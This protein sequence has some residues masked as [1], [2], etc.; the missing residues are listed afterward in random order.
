MKVLVVDNDH[1]TADALAMLLK[2]ANCEVRVAY[3]GPSALDQATKFLPDLLLADLAMPRMD[4]NELAR[5]V[6]ETKSLDRTVLAVISGYA[7]QQ[8]R[9]LATAAGFTE[10]LVKPIPIEVIY[11][12]LSRIRELMVPPT[13]T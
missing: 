5:C 6:R 11:E 3:D 8:H 12:L 9:E 7:D 4:G 2:Y 10:Y 13:A 1:D